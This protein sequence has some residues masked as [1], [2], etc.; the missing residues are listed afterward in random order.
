V[1][2]RAA[3]LDRDGV[4]IADVG[5]LV[6]PAEIDVLAGVPEALSAL[7]A[8]GYALVVVTN[9]TVVARG[10]VTEAELER[11]HAALRER[12]LACGAPEMDATYVCLH[13]P[14]ATLAEYRRDCDCRKPKPGLLLRA[15]DE[16]GLD[17]AASALIG[18]RQSDVIAGSLAGC[19]TVLVRSG[20]HA[21]PA[22][23]TTLKL[24]GAIEPHHVCADFAEA[25]RWI[26]ARG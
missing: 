15:A 21:A 23:E 6:D 24:A 13:H 17:L 12:L 22:I 5:L 4:L 14:N 7:A 2:R 16:L 1:S 10:L 25:A 18:D 26:I 8:A 9:Q 19:A 11:L 20:A 3:F